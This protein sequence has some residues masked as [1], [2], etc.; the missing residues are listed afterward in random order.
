LTQPQ[1][2]RL[3]LPRQKVT[4]AVYRVPG[5]D[6]FYQ[7]LSRMDPEAFARLLSQWLGSRAGTLPAALAM[8]G[9]IDVGW[10]LIRGRYDLRISSLLER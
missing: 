4:R 9:K 7:V 2:R 8:D 6:V 10:F 1:R 5:Y 3:G